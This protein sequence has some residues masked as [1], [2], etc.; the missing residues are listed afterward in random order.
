MQRRTFIK[1]TAAIGA[2]SALPWGGRIA[3][4][5]PAAPSGQWMQ[6]VI[7][8]AHALGAANPTLLYLSHRHQSAQVRK[9][10]L[11]SVTDTEESGFTL[12]IQ[13]GTVLGS[14]SV[15]AARRPSPREFARMAVESAGIARI[16]LP[17]D[18]TGI[19]GEVHADDHV[20]PTSDAADMTQGTWSPAG[21]QDPFLTDPG[22]RIDFL[23]GLNTAATKIT[24]IPYAVANQFLQKR[25]SIFMDGEGRR[26][27]Q[28]QYATYVNFAVTAFSQQ[29]Q[30]MD[31]RTSERE[32]QSTDWAG[33]TANMKSELETAMQE[34]LQLQQSDSITPDSYD[35]VIHPSLLWN[36][37][38]ETLLPHLDPRQLAR[39]D[40]GSPGGRWLTLETFRNRPLRSEVLRMRWDSTLP[41]GLA[42]C[43]WDDTGRQAGSFEIFDGE[44]MLRNIPVSPDL[45]RSDPVYGPGFPGFPFSRAVAWNLPAGVAMPNVVLEGGPGKNLDTLIG[46]VD[47]G[48]F[49]KGRGTVVTNPA[50][51]LFRVRPQVAW[52]IRGGKLAEMLRDVE[53]ETSAEQFWNALEET[54]RAADTFLGGDLFP[55]RA[56]PLWDTPFTVATPPALFRNIPV[57]RV[58]G[59]A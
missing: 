31:T 50:K 45:L 4:A 51:T 32:A 13:L 54:G 29:K 38:I 55:R 15:P 40:G 27:E 35:L 12:R 57:Y 37:L 24:Q 8:E 34:V 21:I 59:R 42:S 44:G 46:G 5:H 18:T 26:F 20:G 23:K 41:R 1:T 2:A 16:V 9:D 17:D 33:A 48:L 30:L 36:I 49:V 22:E 47:N 19:D 53:I 14:A 25:T 58:E 7:S 3:T 43:G 28:R 39:R 11:H 10:T 56:F 52:A 6:D